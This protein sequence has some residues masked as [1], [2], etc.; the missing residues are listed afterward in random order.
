MEKSKAH[1][2]KIKDFL[3]YFASLQEIFF[4]QIFFSVCFC[5]FRGLN[6]IINDSKLNNVSFTS[7]KQ[8]VFF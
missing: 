7:Q 6:L 2:E 8:F 1:R 5:V 4:A 3:M